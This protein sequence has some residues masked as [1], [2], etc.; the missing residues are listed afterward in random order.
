MKDTNK[1]LKL[2]YGIAIAAVM[3]LTFLLNYFQPLYTWDKQLEDLMVQRPTV[4][5]SRIRII[6]ID[7]KTLAELGQHEYMGSEY[8]CRTGGASQCRS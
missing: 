8:P 2:Q 4:T 5:D 1:K 3:L 7:E 6:K